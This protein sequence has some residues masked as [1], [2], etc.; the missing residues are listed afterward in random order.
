[1]FVGFPIMVPA[2]YSWSK[3]IAQ[4]GLWLASGSH[5]KT[6]VARGWIGCKAPWAAGLM[7]EMEGK[8]LPSLTPP[9]SSIASELSS[10]HLGSCYEESKPATEK[11]GS[12]H[13]PI[14]TVA[15]TQEKSKLAIGGWWRELWQS[16]SLTWATLLHAE[17]SKRKHRGKPFLHQYFCTL[18]CFSL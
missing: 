12:N 8:G 15:A 11:R 17:E 18:F 3:A 6:G 9:P 10:Q 4:S 5:L 1:M 16:C 14:T 7:P 2:S 13:P